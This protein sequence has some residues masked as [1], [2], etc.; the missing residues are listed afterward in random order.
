M[1]T[2]EETPPKVGDLVE[3]KSGGPIMT[4]VDFDKD[5]KEVTTNHFDADNVLQIHYFPPSALQT[6]NRTSE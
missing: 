2:S 6:S 1:Q 4:V 3:L 5:K